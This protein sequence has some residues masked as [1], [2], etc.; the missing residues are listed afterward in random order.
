MS[1]G[2]GG[3]IDPDPSTRCIFGAAEEGVGKG[4]DAAVDAGDRQGVLFTYKFVS[5][6]LALTGEVTVSELVAVKALM[7][8]TI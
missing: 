5:S 8:T 4:G 1:D 2:G 3:V 6:L 7:S